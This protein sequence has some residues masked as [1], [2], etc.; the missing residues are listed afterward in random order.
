MSEEPIVLSPAR[1]EVLDEMLAAL[2][3]APFQ[4]TLAECA[5]QQ[6]GLIEPRGMRWRE[7]HAYMRVI[8]A[9]ERARRLRDVG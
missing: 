7:E 5:E 1:I 3:I 6:L 2:P 4:V 8:V 9:Q